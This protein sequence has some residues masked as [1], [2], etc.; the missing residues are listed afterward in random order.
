[1]SKKIKLKAFYP[2]LVVIPALVLF[3]AFTYYPLISTMQYAMTNW[4]GFKSNYDYVGFAN[5]IQLVKDQEVI[6]SFGNTIY[7]AVFS[8]LIGIVLQLG[9]AVFLYGKFRGKKFFRALFYMPC[10]ISQLIASLTWLGFFQYSGV[11]NE[12]LTS[13]GL[14]GLVY[15]WIGNPSSVKN[16]LIFINAWQWTGYGMVIYMA[17]LTAIPIDIYESAQIDG[18]N[19]VQQ[20]FK[21]TIPLIMQAVTIN[22]FIGITGAMKIFDMPFILTKG[23]PMGASKML[24]M[25][26][27]DNAFAYEKF[28]YSSAIGVVFFFF[29]AT[30]TVVQIILTR[31][32]EVEF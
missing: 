20:F 4:N 15:D 10:V 1:M 9:L 3:F 28:G 32:R 27:Y 24:S 6:S 8:I 5:F 22:F 21:I 19:S 26:I 18:A 11:I 12:V 23:G 29:I 31:K 25:T 16:V 2:I 17:G 7:F 30:I 14:S 13:I